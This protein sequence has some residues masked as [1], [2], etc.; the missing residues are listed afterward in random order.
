[1]ANPIQYHNFKYFNINGVT[2]NYS[3][4]IDNPVY[5]LKVKA[6]FEEEQHWL[7]AETKDEAHGNIQ[8]D[9]GV[10]MLHRRGKTVKIWAVH[11]PGHQFVKWIDG[12]TRKDYSSDST[13]YVTMGGS[14]ISLVAIFN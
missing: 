10:N 14:D 7:Y 2:V 12:V 5:S 3:P 4:Y 9:L 13:I 11:E 1:V 8:S 6:Y